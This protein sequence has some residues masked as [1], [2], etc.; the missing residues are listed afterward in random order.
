MLEVT[1]WALLTYLKITFGLAVVVGIAWLV[2]GDDSGWFWI[3]T[4]AAVALD[5]FMG[6]Q[7]VRE[8]GHE[9]SFRWWWAR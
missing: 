3:I 1:G 4:A 7:L 9:A 6:R 8:W 5:L 2:L